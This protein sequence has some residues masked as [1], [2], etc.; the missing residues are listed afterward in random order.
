MREGCGCHASDAGT[1]SKSLVK[2]SAGGTP[3]SRCV[4]A[5]PLGAPCPPPHPCR[6]WMRKAPRF[7]RLFFSRTRALRRARRRRRWRIC[8]SARWTWHRHIE[9]CGRSRLLGMAT[10]G[11]KHFTESWGASKSVHQNFS[12]RRAGVP[13]RL[14]HQNL[15]PPQAL[16]VDVLS[17]SPRAISLTLTRYSFSLSL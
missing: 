6:A 16:V 7:R 1:F 14:V 2:D 12:P 3:A 17:N 11:R 4:A 8:P 9:S 10:D 15:R 13:Q 5:C